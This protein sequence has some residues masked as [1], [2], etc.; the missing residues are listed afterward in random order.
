MGRGPIN[1]GFAEMTKTGAGFEMMLLQIGAS[2]DHIQSG[3]ETVVRRRVRPRNIHGKMLDLPSSA[4]K[5][6]LTA[7][8]SS[9]LLYS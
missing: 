2:G 5:R 9:P 8:I 7:A 1:Q 6:L 4:V 3:R